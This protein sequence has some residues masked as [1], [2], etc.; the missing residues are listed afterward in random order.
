MAWYKNAQGQPVW[1]ADKPAV[2]PVGPRNPRLPAQ[3][4]GDILGNANTAATTGRTVVQ[5]RGDLIDNQTKAATQSAQIRK[6]NAEAA[7]AENAVKGITPEIMQQRAARLAQLN[8]VNKQLRKTWD[9]FSKGPGKTKGMSGLADY[10][11]WLAPNAEFNTAGAGLVHMA[12]NAF[13]TPGVG[14]QSD[15]ELMAMIAADQPRAGD[16]DEAAMAKMGNIET[17]LVEAFKTLGVP[18]QPYRPAGFGQ[19][20]GKTSVIRYDKNGNPIR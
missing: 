18:F 19:P 1:V 17:K 12:Q 16:V 3:V 15:Q 8:A 14:S 7:A 2:T 6:A 10:N 4:Q 13:R 11:P 5:T 20:S 9:A